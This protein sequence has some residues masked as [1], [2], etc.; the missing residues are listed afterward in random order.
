MADQ[1]IR[2]SLSSHFR[3]EGFDAATK[4]IKANQKELQASVR[5]LGELTSAFAGVSPEA[6]AAVG[7][8]KSFVSAFA[9]GG[10]VGGVIQLAISGISKAVEYCT[11]KMEEARKAAKDYIEMLRDGVS[12]NVS[13]ASKRFAELQSQLAQSNKE[14]QDLVKVLNGQ[15]ANEAANKIFEINKRK[16][17]ALA[18]AMSESEKSVIEAVA[19]RE[20]AAVK[21]A[22]AD[23]QSANAAQALASAVGNAT[24]LRSAASDRLSAAEQAV[25]DANSLCA[26]YLY[27]RQKILDR[28]AA[29]D[30]QYEEGAILVAV[31]D[32]QVAAARLELK[33]LDERQKDTVAYLSG[34]NGELAAA[35]KAAADAD[36]ALAQAQ[37]AAQQA[38]VERDTRRVAAETAALDA[39]DKVAK[40]NEK[41]ADELESLI[42]FIDESAEKMKETSATYEELVASAKG[43]K[44]AQDDAADSLANGDDDR[45]SR[46]VT[47]A[48]AVDVKVKNATEIGSSFS[49]SVNVDGIRGDIQKPR[50]LDQETWDRYKSGMANVADVQRVKRFQEM[51]ERYQAK[52]IANDTAKFINLADKPRTWLS[53]RDREFM[54]DYKAKVAPQ[55]AQEQLKRMFQ[56]NVDNVLTTTKMKEVLKNDAIVSAW[57]KKFGMK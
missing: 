22:E 11:A 7:Q 44:S 25:E 38:A 37:S 39:E 48:D 34:V 56:N 24:Q 17:E 8:V 27:A 30:A 55:V 50:K 15:A 46:L 23:A 51:D 19:A 32:Q 26:G 53:E 9:T 20:I 49:S 5:G 29:A 54:N 57:C 40:A 6:Q 13:E 12:A 4:A 21:A 33:N 36:T 43:L 42:Q 1:S 10:I 31:R 52:R 18:N 45:K 2:F 3:G 16:L 14:A 35:R 41:R 28:I 47:Q